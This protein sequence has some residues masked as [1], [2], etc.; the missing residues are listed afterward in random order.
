MVRTDNTS[1]IKQRVAD[2]VR[3]EEEAR[4][5]ESSGIALASTESGP[6][7]GTDGES[8]KNIQTAKEGEEGEDEKRSAAASEEGKDEM[9]REDVHGRRNA[10]RQ[11]SEKTTR[12]N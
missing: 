3:G 7:D 9:V 10:P 5:A 4:A 11:T 12:R 6:H 2:E 8:P 1:R